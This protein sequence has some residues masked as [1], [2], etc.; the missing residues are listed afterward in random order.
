MR[1]RRPR[2]IPGGAVQ[3]G[4]TKTGALAIS[5]EGDTGLWQGLDGVRP[6]QINSTHRTI[7]SL[8]PSPGPLGFGDH[9]SAGARSGTVIGP[10]PSS[11]WREKTSRI[12][13]SENR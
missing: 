5:P 10:L 3:G 1:R 9:A 12:C 11:I 4:R 6:R 2:I 8:R 7:A 13:D